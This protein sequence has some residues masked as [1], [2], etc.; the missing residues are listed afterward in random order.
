MKITDY[1]E[2]DLERT[3]RTDGTLSEIN[4]SEDMDFEDDVLYLTSEKYN[5]DGLITE[6][7]GMC[8]GR[9]FEDY[10][11]LPL[12]W[13]DKADSEGRI[14]IDVDEY[15]LEFIYDNNR[16]ELGCDEF[17][18]VSNE[19][20]DHDSEH[21]SEKYECVFK[22][23]FDGSLFKFIYML[24]CDGEFYVQEKKMSLTQVFHKQE[25]IIVDTYE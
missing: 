25:T 12:P 4:L 17:S 21:N 15:N 13:Q 7:W 2:K 14:V 19:V 11:F 5:K 24:N 6:R 8:D 18:I 22:R 10:K 1:D 9:S 23:S 3:Y 20:L 16:D